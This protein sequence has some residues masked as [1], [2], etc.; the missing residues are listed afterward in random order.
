MTSSKI[1]VSIIIPAYNCA[2]ILPVSLGPVVYQSLNDIEIIIINDASTDNTLEVLKQ[3]QAQFPGKVKVIDSKENRGPGGARNLGLD[4][5]QGDYIGFVDADDFVSDQLFL[6]LYEKAAEGDYDI[7]DCGMI[8]KAEQKAIIYT[9]DNVTGELDDEKRSTLIVGGGYLYT[10]LY[11]HELFEEPRIRL[12]ENCILEDSDVLTYMFAKA[13]NIGNVK[14]VLYQYNN[15]AGS[16]SKIQD[17]Q[18]YCENI[19]NAMKA[20][21]DRVHELSNYHGIKAAV[22]YEIAQMY[23]YGLTM[24]LKAKR[25]GIASGSFDH[26][27]WLKKFAGLSREI[28]TIPYEKNRYIIDKIERIDIENIIENDKNFSLG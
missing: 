18:K 15:E 8:F 6:R 20:N 19:Y 23:V 9:G 2:K 26:I 25:D 17:P 24:C 27:E 13:R 12:R 1:K 16:A 3:C 5:A 28:I 11:R 21:Y 14:D 22:E 7:V 4:E 10:K